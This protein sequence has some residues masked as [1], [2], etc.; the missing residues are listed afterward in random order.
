M[1]S[2][3]FLFVM[4]GLWCLALMFAST[5]VSA[6]M[7]TDSGMRVENRVETVK[8]KSDQEIERRITSINTLITKIQGMKRLTETEK[9]EFVNQA[10]QLITDLQALK[11]KIDAD[12]VLSDLNTD[13]KSIFTSYRVYMVF[14]PKMHI[15]AAADRVLEIVN[16]VQAGLPAVAEKVKTP[17]L[18]AKLDEAKAKLTDAGVQAQKAIDLVAGLV[19]DGGNAGTIQSNQ[20][21]LKNAQAD[22]KLAITDLGIVRNDLKIIRQGIK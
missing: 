2:R 6:R 22:I 17:Q 18:Q 16:D 13:R 3:K 9:N 11:S 12:T 10:R 7:A 21:A 15:L 14:M 20:T 19:A 1:A 8:S 5:R 4:F